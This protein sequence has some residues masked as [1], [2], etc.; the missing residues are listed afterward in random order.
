[1]SILQKN[2]HASSGFATQEG[3]IEAVPGD[4]GTQ[5]K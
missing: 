5:E 2:M 1:M 4:Y 3:E